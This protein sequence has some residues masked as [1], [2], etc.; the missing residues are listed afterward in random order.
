MEITEI[1]E[2]ENHEE[3]YIGGNEVMDVEMN[4]R[5]NKP[6][7]RK[8]RKPVATERLEYSMEANEHLSRIAAEKVEIK[9]NIMRKKL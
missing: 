3:A 2:A 5:K 7:K 6:M 8:N 9:K 4:E 1:V